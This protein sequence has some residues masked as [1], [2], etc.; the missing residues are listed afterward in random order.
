M[1]REAILGEEC[2]LDRKILHI[3]ADA[4]Y[5]SVECL[6]HPALRGKPVAVCGDAEQRHGIVLAKNQFAKQFGIKTGEAIWQAKEKCPKLQILSARFDLY[7]EFSGYL[8]EI[9][10]RYTDQVENFGLDEAWCDVTGSAGLFGNSAAIAKEISETVRRELG[11]TVSVGIAWNKVFAK[12]GSDYR[13]PNGITE[14]TRENYR[15]LIWPRPASDL[16]YVGPA[17]S[18][19]LDGYGIHTIGQL[20]QTDSKWLRRLLG[21]WGGYLWQFANGLDITPVA[22]FGTESPVKSVGNSITTYRDIE[23]CAEAWQ[24][25]LHLSESVS[26][27]L[28]EN[29]LR[30]RTIEISCRDNQLSCAGTQIRLAA[31]TFL[32]EEIAAAAFRL[33][34]KHDSFYRPLRSI[35]VRGMDVVG[36]DC[37]MQLS[38]T[39]NPDKQGRLEKIESCV[40]QLRKR[41]GHESVCRASLLRADILGESGPLTHVIHPVGYFR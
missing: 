34:R 36:L 18:R 14:F 6:Y 12:L 35:G 23:D 15:E 3:D 13:K 31:P 22:L 41:F 32:T 9:Y 2:P 40:D 1:S 7:L 11:I 24:V 4:F 37:G 17:T 30:C 33:L 20:A 28:R 29:A 21:K 27:R 8:R 5:A 26:W 19:K 38:F 10:L 25:I 39:D 16:L